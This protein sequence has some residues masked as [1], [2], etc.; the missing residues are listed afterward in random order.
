MDKKE[1][2]NTIDDYTQALLDSKEQRDK[3]KTAMNKEDN[4]LS[5]EEK[6]AAEGRL[7]NALDQLRKQRGQKSIRQEEREYRRRDRDGLDVPVFTTRSIQY[8]GE[9]KSLRAIQKELDQKQN[10]DRHTIAKTRLIRVDE[11]DRPLSRK[12]KKE[13]DLSLTDTLIQK[14]KTGRIKLQRLQRTLTDP[15]DVETHGVLTE[16]EKRQF[17]FKTR[18][19]SILI[20]VC[21]LAL[22]LTG[23]AY[24]TL[25]YDP[26]HTVTASMQKTYD[27]LVEYADEWDMSSDTEKSE[28]LRY[29][30]RYKRLL[31]SQK[32]DINAYFKEQTGESL[33]KIFK[34][35]KQT[36][37]QARTDSMARLE[38]F[39]NNWYTYTNDQKEMV[40]DYLD[41]YQQLDDTDR[42]QID[43]LSTQIT[44]MDFSSL[45]EEEQRKANSNVD[46]IATLNTQLSMYEQYGEALVTYQDDPESYGFTEEQLQ[47]EIEA[48][49][50]IIDSLKS[51]IKTLEEEDKA[52]K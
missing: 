44:G 31:D 5:H 3:D 19:I 16:K 50:S 36:Q 35:L 7:E 24:K 38:T 20:A 25:V 8:D 17:R 43:L 21:V 28:L 13:S 1:T 12:R 15:D 34:D 6:R 23:Y 48:N 42:Q 51:Q 45:V 40:I 27:K 26:A 4:A 11:D 49:D 14:G 32:S 9:D 46:E 39:L 52:K 22:L 18:L 41:V 33:T 2:N 47:S 29:R 30:S 10:R 37:T